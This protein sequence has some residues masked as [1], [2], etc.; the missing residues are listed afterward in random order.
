MLQK[1]AKGKE[2]K[3]TLSLSGP[4][5]CCFSCTSLERAGLQWHHVT[6]D[7]VRQELGCEA[8]PDLNTAQE[9][10]RDKR[11]QR[12]ENEEPCSGARS[13]SM[14]SG[15]ANTVASSKADMLLSVKNNTL[16]A[17]KTEEEIQVLPHHRK[18]KMPKLILLS[19]EN[20]PPHDVVKLQA[21]L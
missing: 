11:S 15:I 12:W 18:N 14:W 21:L 2:E 4:F 20:T 17:Q 3:K 16:V 9:Y 6:A 1:A 19:G 13:W 8:E 5:G 10:S 7:D